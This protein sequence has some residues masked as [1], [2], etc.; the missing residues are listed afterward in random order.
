MNT[1]FPRSLSD[2]FPADRAAAIHYVRR[3]P[4]LARILWPLACF[5]GCICIGVILY[6]GV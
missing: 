1:R 2:A 4:L 6:L 3:P 5:A